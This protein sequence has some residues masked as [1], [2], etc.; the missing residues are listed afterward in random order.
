MGL[1]RHC[2]EATTAVQG[3]RILSLTLPL[4]QINLMKEGRWRRSRVGRHGGATS[5]HHMIPQ[6]RRKS[7]R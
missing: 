2:H 6:S 1:F 3:Q 4:V 7:D 5:C